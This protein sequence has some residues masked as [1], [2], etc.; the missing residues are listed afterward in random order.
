MRKQKQLARVLKLKAVHAWANPHR[1]ADVPELAVA[2]TVSYV[3][4]GTFG[5]EVSL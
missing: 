5:S 1:N 4:L 3:P 2:C